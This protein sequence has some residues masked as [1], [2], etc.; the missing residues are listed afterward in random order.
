MF[1]ITI[2]FYFYHFLSETNHF[3]KCV[4]VFVFL[5]NDYHITNLHPFFGTCKFLHKFLFKN[6][7]V[8]AFR[9]KKVV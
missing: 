7:I 8:D 6:N 1:I 3:E 4:I 2:E 9:L 5:S